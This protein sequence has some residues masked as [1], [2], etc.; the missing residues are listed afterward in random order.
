MDID[1]IYLSIARRREA[2]EAAKAEIEWLEEF[3]YDIASEGGDVRILIDKNKEIIKASER[4]IKAY[5]KLLPSP[6]Q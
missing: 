3:T 2:I 6:N 4:L 1:G 5:E